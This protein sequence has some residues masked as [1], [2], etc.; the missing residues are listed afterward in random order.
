META[1]LAGDALELAHLMPGRIRLR[2]RGEG[3]PPARL[4][5][6]LAQSAGVAQV[7]YRPAS[8]SLLIRHDAGIDLDG[9]RHLAGE[10]EVPLLEPAPSAA[11]PAA[12]LEAGLAFRRGRVT[13]RDLE[14]VL[15]LVL[16][17]TWV[18]DL[19]VTR[20]FRLSTFL[21]ILIT[22]VSLCQAWW[23]ARPPAPEAPEGHDLAG[24]LELL[25]R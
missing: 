6:R 16:V 13:I 4:V 24:E 10:F 3:E 25:D 1:E 12:P 21:L 11:R 2:W 17:I 20:T 22:C 7:E 23:S 19:I 8:R 15:A 9:V 18:R 14:A 5:E